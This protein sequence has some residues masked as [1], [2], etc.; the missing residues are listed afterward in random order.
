MCLATICL[1]IQ[2]LHVS[3]CSYFSELIKRYRGKVAEVE[4][5]RR[6][7][8]EAQ[9]QVETMEQSMK[10]LRAELQALHEVSIQEVVGLCLTLYYTNCEELSRFCYA[11]STVHSF[12]CTRVCALTHHMQENEQLNA[13]LLLRDSELET[14]QITNHEDTLL[15]DQMTIQLKENIK[16]KEEYDLLFKTQNHTSHE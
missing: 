2:C 15:I 11:Y 10:G 14:M 6:S 13:K 12:V 3:I 8:K 9:S 1:A 7:L 5:S 4:S 16:I